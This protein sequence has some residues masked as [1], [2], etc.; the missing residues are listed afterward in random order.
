LATQSRDLRHRASA[1]AKRSSAAPMP[2][3]DYFAVSED[4]RQC[5]DHLSLGVGFGFLQRAQHTEHQVERAAGGPPETDGDQAPP[6]YQEIE[7]G[8][9]ANPRSLD[10]VR[11][12]RTAI[13]K[14]KLN[15]AY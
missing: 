12:I 2:S 13:Q 4:S 14:M 1:T 11:C 9:L 10:S 6:G 3:R 15:F 7:P 5:V 8:L